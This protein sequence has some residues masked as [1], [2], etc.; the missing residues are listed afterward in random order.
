MSTKGSSRVAVVVQ[1]MECSVLEE[2][3]SQLQEQLAVE[4]HFCDPRALPCRRGLY[5]AIQ[6]DL[7]G[8]RVVCLFL[9]A[10]R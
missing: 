4:V 3:Q 7:Q 5:V 9:L 2:E 8:E 10:R 6:V 1:E